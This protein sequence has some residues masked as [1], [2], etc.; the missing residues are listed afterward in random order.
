MTGADV[1]TLRLA[2][3]WTLKQMAAVIDSSA[4][5]I[6]RWEHGTMAVP[7]RFVALLQGLPPP[8]T[9]TGAE[10]VAFRVAHGWSQRQVADALAYGPSTL[11]EYESGRRPVPARIVAWVQSFPPVLVSR[12]YHPSPSGLRQWFLR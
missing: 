6:W 10:L 11:Y 12:N 2:H 5:A 4:T 8:D 3:H 7:E 9:M 1:Y